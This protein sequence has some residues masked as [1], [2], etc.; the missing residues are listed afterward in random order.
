[1]SAS[2]VL[3]N[4]LL[5]QLINYQLKLNNSNSKELAKNQL[6]WLKESAQEKS[7]ASTSYNNQLNK[8]VEEIL[9]LMVKDLVIHNKPLAYI[10][11]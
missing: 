1:M 9:E 10:I 5:K 2:K 6:R 3:G 11:G 7:L 4:S 8:S